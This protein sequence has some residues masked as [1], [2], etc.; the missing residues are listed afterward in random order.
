M[1]GGHRF[2]ERKEIRD[3][4]A[5]L[6]VI[7][8]PNDSMRLRRIINEPKRSIGDKTIASAEEIA[9][10][11]GM[12]LFEVIGRADEFDTLRRAAPKLQAFA[13]TMKELIEESQDSSISLHDLYQ[14]LL[15]KTDYVAYLKAQ[16]DESE[17]R[18][19][20]INELASNLIQF[21]K[22][23]PE[24]AS[25]SMFLEEVSLMTDIDNYDQN[26]DSVV[27]MTLHLSLI[28]I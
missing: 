27:M 2:Y 6:S 3:M 13:T 16:N 21:E 8:N 19:E 14:H 24:D 10:V 23:N 25:I 18:I 17:T 15:F 4:I 12:S 1:I 7:A 22:E 9:S 11:V 26:A 28:N 20:N 5:Y